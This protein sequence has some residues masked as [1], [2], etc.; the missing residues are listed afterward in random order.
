MLLLVPD[1]QSWKM[2]SP[3]LMCAHRSNNFEN[4]AFTK[5]RLVLDMSD[6]PQ[7]QQHISNSTKTTE[8]KNKTERKRMHEWSA[9]IFN[10]ELERVVSEKDGHDCIKKLRTTLK[11]PNNNIDDCLNEDALETCIDSMFQ[12]EDRMVDTIVNDSVNVESNLDGEAIEDNTDDNDVDDVSRGKIHP[13]SVVDTF[14]IAEIELNKVNINQVRMNKK[15][16]LDRADN[17]YRN[18]YHTILNQE[19]KFDMEC[20]VINTINIITKPWFRITYEMLK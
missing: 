16:R 13:L 15:N 19:D 8:P 5:Q 6:E 14:K 2:H 12:N 11:N 4:D 17:F 7:R 9:M 1:E 3:N 18:I 10:N 20:S